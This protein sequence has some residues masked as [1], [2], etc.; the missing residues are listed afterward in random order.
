VAARPCTLYPLREPALFR[1]L[2]ELDRRRFRQGQ[3]HA[4]AAAL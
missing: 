1:P 4:L 2:Q 3:P